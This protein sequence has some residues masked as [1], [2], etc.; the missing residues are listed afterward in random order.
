MLAVRIDLLTGRYAATA[1]NDRQRVEW[2]PHPA[3]L[4]SA[5]VATWAEGAPGTAEGDGE[6]AALR[7]LEGQP[8]PEIVASPRDAAGVRAAVTV[9]VPVNDVGVIRSADRSKLDA[10]ERALADAPPAVRGKLDKEVGK[11][12]QKLADDTARAIAAPSKFGKHDAVA[13]EQSLLERRTRQPRAFPCATPEVPAFAFVWRAA[14]PPADVRDALAR[15]AARLVRLGHSSSLVHARIATPS[16]IDELA[17]LTTSFVADETAGALMVRWVGEGQVDRLVAAHGQHQQVEPRV[18]PARF[19]R[20]REG[21]AAPVRELPV[22]VFSDDPRDWIVFARATGPR[23]P[24]TSVA[25]LSR[26][27]RRALMSVADQPVAEV[28]SG[29]RPDGPASEAPHLAIVPLPVVIGPYADGALLG[30]ALVLPRD[31]AAGDRRAVQRAV[32]HLERARPPIDPSGDPTVTLQLAPDSALVLARVAF[33]EP[34]LVT[35]RAST[36]TR[37]SRRWAS[38]TPVALD[39]NPGDLHHSDPAAR[40]RAFD[41]ARTSVIEA[42]ARIGLPAPLEVDVVRSCV[43]PGTAKPRAYP[44]FPI[45]ARKPQRVL[46]HVRV[47]FAEP[48]RGPILLGAGRYHGVGLLAPVDDARTEGA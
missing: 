42:I 47:S 7:W 38:A 39:R 2:P 44:R 15:L 30:I 41:A 16:V 1:Y 20:Y 48:V 31:L 3:R 5:L 6:L 17:P 43:L 37:P 13:A 8:A 40:A 45:D 14:E 19:V 22:S 18:L 24:I 32:G 10:A 4:F 36:W 12:R 25:G 9:F 35:L 28:I 46:V 33:G 29:H 26:L 11:L 23:L 27:T 21:G 34:A